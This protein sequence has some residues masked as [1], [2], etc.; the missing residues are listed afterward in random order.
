M[1]PCAVSQLFFHGSIWF[2]RE[3]SWS[4][5]IPCSRLIWAVKV[6]TVMMNL[7]P[8]NN[9]GL[10]LSSF[11]FYFFLFR[12]CL[13]TQC[14]SGCF[15][16]PNVSKILRSLS[17]RSLNIP[18]FFNPLVPAAG[19]KTNG[20]I[21]KEQFHFGLDFTHFKGQ[22]TAAVSSMIIQ[23][24]ATASHSWH[25]NTTATKPTQLFG[26]KLGTILLDQI[27]CL[28][29]GDPG[30]NMV[31]VS[32]RQILYGTTFGEQFGAE[33]IVAD[34]NGDDDNDLIISAPTWTSS[35]CYDCGRIYVYHQV[36]GELIHH[37]YVNGQRHH[38][39]FG[40]RYVCSGWL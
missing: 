29:I 8:W 13:K 25:V 9:L 33:F 26:S 24:N 11:S 28:I 20:L 35:S 40:F 23:W 32:P 18:R 3:N 7:A 27:E 37:H 36:N 30:A 39:Q 34:L 16:L 10:C 1:F 12:F 2:K 17:Q 22:S 5:V 31:I 4:C 14:E 38:G 21:D 6:S 19:N 15:I